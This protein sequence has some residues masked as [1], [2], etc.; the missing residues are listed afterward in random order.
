M[1]LVVFRYIMSAMESRVVILFF[2]VTTSAATALTKAGGEVELGEDV[3]ITV[4]DKGSNCKF[5]MQPDEGGLCCYLPGEVC[6]I[7]EQSE[8]CNNNFD[9][10]NRNGQCILSLIDIQITDGGTYEAEGEYNIEVKV[11]P[12]PTGMSTGYQILIGIAIFVL[13]LIFAIVGYLVY[14]HQ[15]RKED[16][17]GLH[18]KQLLDV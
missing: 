9:V 17:T 18:S 1:S 5:L 2:L 7:Q 11:S 8:M 12:I 15:T 6:N 3:T 13:I 14:K 10:V 4:E 16:Q